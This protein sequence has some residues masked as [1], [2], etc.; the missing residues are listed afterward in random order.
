MA[1]VKSTHG[2]ER[3]PDQKPHDK[4]RR[5]K[6]KQRN[7][8]F[9]SF[10]RYLLR[11]K[12]LYCKIVTVN[13]TP[14][15]KKTLIWKEILNETASMD[16][17][18]DWVCIYWHFVCLVS[19]FLNCTQLKI[20]SVPQSSSLP[21]PL[22]CRFLPLNSF[23]SAV[24]SGIVPLCAECIWSESSGVLFFTSSSLHLFM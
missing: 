24:A 11:V 22:L 5:R 4:K 7:K 21:I 9:M 14:R 20:P 13:G 15:K 8:K 18:N 6:K 19:N 23:F 12:V 1:L 17:Y 2:D 16:S 10:M 3:L